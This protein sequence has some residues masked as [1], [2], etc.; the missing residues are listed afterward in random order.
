MDLAIILNRASPRKE[1]A[2]VANTKTEI[3]APKEFS[4][5]FRRR[6]AS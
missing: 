6:P 2:P 4:R 1:A 5:R 3:R